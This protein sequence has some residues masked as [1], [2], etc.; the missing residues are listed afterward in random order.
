MTV[1]EPAHPVIMQRTVLAE[2]AGGSRAVW[3][4]LL[5]PELGE[6]DVALWH[7]TMLRH[8]ECHIQSQKDLLI[9]KKAYGLQLHFVN[10]NRKT[11]VAFWNFGFGVYL[12]SHLYLSKTSA[13]PAHTYPGTN[14]KQP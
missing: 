11:C 5:Q 13:Q 9:P 10:F 1:S 8:F 12:A 7:G 3:W 4:G 6:A 14:L 2:R